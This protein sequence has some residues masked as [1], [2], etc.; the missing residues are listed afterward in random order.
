MNVK[1]FDFKSDLIFSSLSPSE[2]EI[3]LED[4][5]PLSFKKN[6]LLF[7][8]GGIPTGV[9]IL[10]RGK[11]KIYKLG[12][13][14]KPQIFY[15]YKENDLMG[16]H[17]LLCN[18]KYE[19]SC[20]VIEDCE[21]LFISKLQLEER[22]EKIPKLKLLLIQNMSHEFG[23]MVNTITVLAQKPLRDRL[24]LFLLILKERYQTETSEPTIINLPREDLANI[25]GTARESLGRLLKEFAEDELIRIKGRSIEILNAEA[26]QNIASSRYNYS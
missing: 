24:A 19:D 2:K 18:E 1:K 26:L 11:A 5:E 14:G 3:F 6:S 21:L 22:M 12:L 17:A 9:F 23:V 13:D 7:F 10:K 8:D 4:A 16:Y 15:I 25:I 20:E